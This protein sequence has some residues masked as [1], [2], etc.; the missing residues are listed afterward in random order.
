MFVMC[1]ANISS[2][3]GFLFRWMYVKV[4]CG[5]CNYRKKKQQES[6]SHKNFTTNSQLAETRAPSRVTSANP[7]EFDNAE[8][9]IV[10]DNEDLEN[11]INDKDDIEG[12]SVPLT[13][14]ILVV[15]GYILSGAVLFH[16]TDGFG[17]IESAYFC[18]VTLTTIGKL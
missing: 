8:A 17:L 5:I 18:F 3:L 1:L 15:T 6:E 13:I 7:S 11:E 4:C 2:V 9:R 14:T 10:D 12:V 16:F